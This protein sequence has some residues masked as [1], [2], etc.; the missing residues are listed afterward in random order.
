MKK[1]NLKNVPLLLNPTKEKFNK[2]TQIK[3][4]MIIV[5]TLITLMAMTIAIEEQAKLLEHQKTTSLSN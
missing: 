5:S 3:D 4:L 1:K 2:R